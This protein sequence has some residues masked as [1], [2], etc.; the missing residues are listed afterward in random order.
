MAAEMEGFV[1]R[2]KRYW[3]VALGDAKSSNIPLPAPSKGCLLVVFVYF[4]VSKK[5]PWI[6]LEG[7]GIF[8]HILLKG[9]KALFL[10]TAGYLPC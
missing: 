8:H 4:K 3:V 5:H 2:Q 6:P 9:L 7:P 1:Y 10:F